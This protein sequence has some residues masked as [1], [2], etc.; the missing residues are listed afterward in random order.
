[1]GQGQALSLWGLHCRTRVAGL[2]C[3]QAL[4]VH[5][6][7]WAPRTYRSYRV[8]CGC[9]RCSSAP[10]CCPPLPPALLSPSGLGVPHLEHLLAV[11][12]SSA[13]TMCLADSGTSTRVHSCSCRVWALSPLALWS[14]PHDRRETTQSVDSVT[15]RNGS[16]CVLGTE[17]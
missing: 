8:F 10:S 9:L 13:E 15:L 2:P 11:V 6:H 17:V 12:L 7:L 5:P 3:S 16:G 4:R 14:A 1:M